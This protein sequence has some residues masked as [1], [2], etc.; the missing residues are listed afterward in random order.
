MEAEL[1]TEKISTFHSPC[2]ENLGNSDSIGK[3]WQ[4]KILAQTKVLKMEEY[5]MYF[6]FS[7]LHGWGKRFAA[8]PKTIDSEVP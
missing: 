8:Q 5:C 6:L 1:S 2:G 3:S 7:E 4:R